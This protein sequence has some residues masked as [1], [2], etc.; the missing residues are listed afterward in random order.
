MADRRQYSP[1]YVLREPAQ[2]LTGLIGSQILSGRFILQYTT[3]YMVN[4][5]TGSM[6]Q[7]LT[8]DH[9]EASLPHKHPLTYAAFRTFSELFL[10]NTF[11]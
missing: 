3:L 8:G 7:S 1:I 9:D 5:L 4:M 11:T 6:Q 10:R 2:H